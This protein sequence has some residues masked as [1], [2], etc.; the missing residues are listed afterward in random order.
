MNGNVVDALLF[1]LFTPHN[2]D[3]SGWCWLVVVVVHIGHSTLL[4]MVFFF[5]FLDPRLVNGSVLR[6]MLWNTVVLRG[7][8]YEREECA[9]GCRLSLPAAAG[10]EER[11]GFVVVIYLF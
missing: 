1:F 3:S 5:F 10:G 11:A 6:V 8:V 4:L 7:E 9:L 2:R